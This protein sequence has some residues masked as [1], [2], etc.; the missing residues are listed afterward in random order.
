M[1]Y[2]SVMD[3]TDGNDRENEYEQVV[4]GGDG[5]NEY[6]LFIFRKY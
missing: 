6:L 4:E 5:E 1:K 3:D 2:D